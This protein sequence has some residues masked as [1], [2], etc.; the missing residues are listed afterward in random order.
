M[1]FIKTIETLLERAERKGFA[2]VN[3][4]I[5]EYYGFGNTWQSELQEKYSVTVE[6][7]IVTLTHWGTE[8][9]KA[10]RE[11]REVLSWYGESNSDRDS[12][13]TLLYLLGI[14]G[15]F[16]YFPSKDEFIFED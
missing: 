16:R 8:T 11:A 10:D 15:G 13:N 6:G 5:T 1:K 2:R 9:L 7:N 14:D 3:G 4:R 12:M